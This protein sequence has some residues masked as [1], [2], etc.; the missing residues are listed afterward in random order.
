MSQLESMMWGTDR[1]AAIEYGNI[2]HEILSYINSVD[3]VDLAVQKA[4]EN[5]LITFFQKETMMHTILS[6]VKNEHLSR[7]SR[8]LRESPT[9]KFARMQRRP[10]H[11]H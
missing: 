1:Q 3:D 4:L 6:I 11:R 8:M 5:G 9:A 10:R 7:L 2:V